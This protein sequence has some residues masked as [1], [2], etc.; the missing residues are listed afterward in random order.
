MAEVCEELGIPLVDLFPVFETQGGG[1]LFYDLVHMIPKGHR[2]AAEELTRALHELGWLEIALGHSSGCV[3]A[4]ETMLLALSFAPPHWGNYK[5][6]SDGLAG[7][8]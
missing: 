8:P 1:E 4:G 6:V 7:H 2:L 3:L 5:G